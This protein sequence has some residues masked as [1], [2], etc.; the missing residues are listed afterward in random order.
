M[1]GEP[2]RPAVDAVLTMAPP[3]FWASICFSTYFRPRNTPRTFT[4]MIWSNIA[5]S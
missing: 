1:P 5:S 2:I 4:A 3:P